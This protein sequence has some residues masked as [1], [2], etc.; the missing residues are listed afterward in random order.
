M[1]LRNPFDAPPVRAHPLPGED[2]PTGELG[3][4]RPPAPLLDSEASPPAPEGDVLR[5][6]FVGQPAEYARLWYVN[7]F[8]TL[9]SVGLYSPWA[10]VSQRAYIASRTLVSGQP[11]VYHGKPLPILKGRLL[12]AALVLACWVLASFWPSTR[13]LIVAAAILLAPWFLLATFS[14]NAANHSWRGVHFGFSARYRDAILV[15]LPLLLW[16]A[17]MVISDHVG[18]ADDLGTLLVLLAPALAYLL[19]W[20][21][22]VAGLTRLRAQ[23]LRYGTAKAELAASIKDFYV[24]YF[25]GMSEKFATLVFGAVIIASLAMKFGDVDAAVLTKLAAAAV[26]AALGTGYARG[27]RLN[28]TLH[29]LTVGGRIRFRSAMTP[30]KLARMYLVNACWLTV[31]LGLAAPWRQ[32]ITMRARCECITVHVD[33]TLDDITSANAPRPGALGESVA[34]AL[35]LD[36]AL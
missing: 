35:N 16:P 28:L 8:L 1:R 20:P 19:A 26:A 9:V 27:R 6:E 22:T 13:P 15:M 31:T 36:L 10:K 7:L 2:D 32:I 11:V 23:G 33:G 24:L 18:T 4:P 25:R 21:Y 30:E 5:I 12:A 29:R 17:L 3:R 34:E 14:F